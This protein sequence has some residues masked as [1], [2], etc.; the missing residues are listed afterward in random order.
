MFADAGE[1]WLKRDYQGCLLVGAGGL[2]Q[3]RGICPERAPRNRLE[4][5]T[6]VLRLVSSERSKGPLGLGQCMDTR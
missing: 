5:P 3:V 6:L 4:G 2:H 1:T